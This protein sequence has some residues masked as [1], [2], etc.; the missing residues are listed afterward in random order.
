MSR[1]VKFLIGLAA[2]LLMAWIHHGPLGNGEAFVSGL[3][4]HAR[5]AVSETELAGIEVQLERN[6]LSRAAT[7]SGPADEFQREGQGEL[8][9]LNDLVAEVEGV[10]DV[11]W[12]DQG[13]ADPGLPLLVELLIGVLVA[14]L[15]GVALAKLL[16]GRPKKESYL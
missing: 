14:Y 2:A 8:K 11:G 6:P 7:L 1:T 9:G 10:S 13:G 12:A 3:E 15:L 5:S 4:N 16:F